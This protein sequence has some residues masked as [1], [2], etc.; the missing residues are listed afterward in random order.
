MT[1]AKVPKS[2]GASTHAMATPSPKLP[3]LLSTWLTRPQANRDD[4]LPRSRTAMTTSPTVGRQQTGHRSAAP[5]GRHD[6]LRRS[7]VLERRV[8]GG[9]GAVRRRLRQ[10]REVAA[11]EEVR[12]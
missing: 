6:A 7:P 12:D 10:R 5:D 1:T 4:C 9:E 8:L 11:E 2:R 3:A